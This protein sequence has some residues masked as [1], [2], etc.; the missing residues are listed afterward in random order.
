[1]YAFFMMELSRYCCLPCDESYD[2]MMY[3]WFA[4]DS[5]L[6]V[7]WTFLIVCYCMTQRSG[8]GSFFDS[9]YDSL[10]RSIAKS[11]TS[12]LLYLRSSI[13]RLPLFLFPSSGNL[14]SR[15]VFQY[16]ELNSEPLSP[17]LE[18]VTT[19]LYRLCL[20]R[21]VYCFTSWIVSLSYQRFYRIQS[22]YRAI[23]P[24]CW[25][26]QFTFFSLLPV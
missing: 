12:N 14:R 9:C 10:L 20:L 11:R 2:S 17:C 22:A 7:I 15:T 18:T 13:S 19:N 6:R 23:R 25:L 4:N 8:D 24:K 3:D 21:V 5:M 1:M 16:T 26:A